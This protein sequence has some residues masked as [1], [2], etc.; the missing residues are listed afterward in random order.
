MK[1]IDA[2]ERM[3]CLAGLLRDRERLKAIVEF[4]PDDRQNDI[5]AAIEERS[6]FSQEQIANELRSVLDSEAEV[7]TH[8]ARRKLG[9]N[10]LN[11][12]DLPFVLRRWIFRN[13]K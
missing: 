9:T 2:H 4:L 8:V 1:V 13:E 6:A 7:A 11:L 3:L 5:R 12:G 10:S